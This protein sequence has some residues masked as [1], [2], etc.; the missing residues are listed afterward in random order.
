MSTVIVD[1]PSTASQLASVLER[2][3]RFALDSEAAGFHRYSDRICL[4]QVTVQ[5]AT[6][7]VDTLAFDPAPFLQDALEDPERAV[8]IHG[9]DYDL[10]LLD[11]DLEI[12]PRGVVD[13][14]VAASLLGEPAT[15][16]SALLERHLGVRL[17]KKFQRAD[18]AQRPLPDELVEYAAGDTRHLVQ[19]ADLL[20]DRLRARGRLS[21]AR[22]EFASL[23]GIR[24]SA[25]PPPDPVT[26]VKGAKNLA[27]RAL[28]ALRGLLEWRDRVARELDRALFRVAEDSA[29]RRLAESPPADMNEL[30]R[31]RGVSKSLLRN[32]GDALLTLLRDAETMPLDEIEPFPRIGNGGAG[33]PS[34]DVEERFDRLKAIRNQ[35]AE[36]LE[37]DRGVL[38]SNAVLMSVAELDPDNLS[39]LKSS[40]AIKEW[41]IAAF[42]EQLILDP[43][44]AGSTP[45]TP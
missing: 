44:S 6:Y 28:H 2:V 25:E 7:L 32:R 9:S 26:R 39:E 35:R 43:E 38:L 10:R 42:G 34:R 16:L 13:T 45:D 21:W 30:L 31:T 3:P 29:L 20:M 1:N 12:N 8:V 5:D 17:S 4:L 33:R 36:E 41:Q 27:P 19:L 24:W 15:G 23:E 14:Q 37:L 11:R 18:W 40:V 22:E